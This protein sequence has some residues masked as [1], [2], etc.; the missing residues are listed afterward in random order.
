MTINIDLSDQRPTVS[1]L[2]GATLVVIGALVII[3][4]AFSHELTNR[5]VTPAKTVPTLVP[6][7]PQNKASG[8]YSSQ[9]P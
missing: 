9:A 1:D 2:I 8:A 5:G 3:G 7:A 6:A 4:F